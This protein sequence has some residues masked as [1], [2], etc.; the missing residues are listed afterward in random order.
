M[1]ASRDIRSILGGVGA[2]L[3]AA[4]M[5]ACGGN[6]DHGASDGGG[7]SGSGCTVTLSGAIS[8]TAPCTPSGAYGPKS[9][10][11]GFAISNEGTS[12]SFRSFHFSIQLPGT[13]LQTGTFTSAN[14]AKAATIVSGNAS[15]Q[16]WGQYFNSSRADQGTF[17]LTLTSTGSEVDSGGDKAW[18]YAHGS[19]TAM[20]APSGSA[21]GAVDVSVTF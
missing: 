5:A 19:L 16:I 21:S 4:A 18:P 20:L 8:A 3:A 17:S 11:L 6:P 15:T 12:S 1:R 7:G 9:N 14:S 13:S 10:T 2:A